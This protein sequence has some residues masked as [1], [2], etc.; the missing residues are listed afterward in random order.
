MRKSNSNDVCRGIPPTAADS[1]PGSLSSAGA[2]SLWN[3]RTAASPWYRSP[4]VLTLNVRTRSGSK[5]SSRREAA[6]SERAIR[7]APTRSTMEIPTCTATRTGLSHLLR[8]PD[9][10]ADDARRAATV[11]PREASAGASPESRPAKNDRARQNAKMRRSTEISFSRG[12]SAGAN[13]TSVGTTQSASR[14]P[15]RP[16]ARAST[17]R[18][19]DRHFSRSAG[20]AHEQQARNVRAG[21]KKHAGSAREQNPEC[22]L[23]SFRDAL[24]ERRDLDGPVRVLLRI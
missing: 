12:R 24:L 11:T 9:E 7:P 6:S 3:A 22:R 17:N 2:R 23:G 19:T 10:S 20:R 8:G 1:T 18:H 16:P 5:P 15:P 14:N 21:D 13:D 4:R